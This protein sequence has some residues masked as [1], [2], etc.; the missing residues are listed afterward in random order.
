M[1]SKENGPN[2]LKNVFLARYEAGIFFWWILMVL[3]NKHVNRISKGEQKLTYSPCNCAP[4]DANCPCVQP[5]YSGA[6]TSHDEHASST[7]GIGMAFGSWFAEMPK[8][9]RWPVRKP[10]LSPIFFALPCRSLQILTAYQSEWIRMVIAFQSIARH[11]AIHCPPHSNRIHSIHTSQW[12]TKV[13]PGN[14]IQI[15]GF[16]PAW[17]VG[18]RLQWLKSPT[19]VFG[20]RVSEQHPDTPSMLIAHDITWLYH[21]VRV[22]IQ[23]SDLFQA[24]TLE[25]GRIP[26]LGIP[27]RDI[28]SA[29]P[30]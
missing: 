1:S 29:R 14:P 12:V 26:R 20:A 10:P 21:I 6:K 25:L 19:T 2:W 11:T 17:R 13:P 18:Y 30:S 16:G 7:E 3:C 27:I 4:S 5:D 22:P 24:T 8:F 28:R 15:R 9:H 23:C